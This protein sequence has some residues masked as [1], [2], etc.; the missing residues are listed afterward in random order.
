MEFVLLWWEFAVFDVY[1][2]NDNISCFVT[3]KCDVR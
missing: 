3:A 1:A 2:H